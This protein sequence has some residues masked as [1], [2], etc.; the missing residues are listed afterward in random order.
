MSLEF[1]AGAIFMLGVV[2]IGAWLRHRWRYRLASRKAS[3]TPRMTGIEAAGRA[4]EEPPR[5]QGKGDADAR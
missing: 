4:T 5:L 3:L 1:V 2:F